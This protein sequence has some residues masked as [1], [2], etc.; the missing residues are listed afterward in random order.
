MKAQVICIPG[1]VAP[2]AQRYRPL[3]DGAGAAAELHLKDLEVYREA[4]PPSD[5][6]IDEELEAIDRFADSNGLDRFHLI[7]YSGGGFISLAYA[8]TRPG[9]LLS[10]GLFE[11]AQIPGRLTDEEQAFFTGLQRKLEGL[12]GDQFMA[13]FIREQVKPG[14]Q[15][16]PPPPG[17]VSPEM[18]KRPAGIAA[19]IK[20]FGAY[21][22]DRELLE[23]A[24]FPVFYGYGDLSHPEQAL[25]AGILARLFADIRVH[26]YGGVH[27]FVPPEM[28]YTP[29]HVGALLD[30][31]QRGEKL[32]VQLSHQ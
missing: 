19:L 16:A 7:G 9:R 1:S 10:L 24:A 3:I 4:A 8:G 23:E 18:Q 20:A 27:H 15:L 28:I 22:F 32:A 26:R 25:K 5:Y 30:L 31:W 12:S 2:A 11:P 17:P 21:P 13:T 6:S 29:D 14:T